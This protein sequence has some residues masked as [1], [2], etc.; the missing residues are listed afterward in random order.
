MTARALM[1]AAAVLLLSAPARAE[2]ELVAG[3]SQDAVQITSNYTGTDLVVFGAIESRPQQESPSS[4]ETVVVVVRGPETEMTVRRKDRVAG[5][6]INR[7]R[8]RFG[9]MPSYYFLAST[10]PLSQTASADTLKSYDLGLANQRPERVLSDGDPE[11]YRQALI[12]RQRAAG[13]YTES[14]NSV[15]FL[16]PNLFRVHVP[17]PASVPRGQYNVQVYLF[18]DGTIISAQSTPLFVEQTGIERRVYLFA[19]QWALTY[20]VLAVLM[21]TLLGWLSALVFRR[22]PG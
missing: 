8:A 19:H 17:V 21:A 20:G 22:R 13:L 5:I 1:T 15:E 14:P 2:E 7:E 6:W 3:V 18:R 10:R 4:R 16:S 11:P 12:R 9:G